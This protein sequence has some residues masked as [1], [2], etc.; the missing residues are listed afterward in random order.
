MLRQADPAFVLNAMTEAFLF[1]R[2]VCEV[3]ANSHMSRVVRAIDSGT[4][5]VPN[6]APGV[7]QYLIFE[8]ADGDVRKH[9]VTVNRFDTAW[10]LRALHHA[11]TGLTQLHGEGLAHQDLK[12]S[13]VLVFPEKTWKIGDLGRA[14]S[15]D[16]RSPHDGE[17]VAGDRAYAPPELL[18]H[19]PDPDWGK[20]RFG[21]DA[22]LLGSMVLFLFAQNGMTALMMDQLDTTQHWQ[23]WTGTFDEIL[24]YLRNAYGAALKSIEPALPEEHRPDLMNILRQLCDPD[25]KLRGHPE[26]RKRIGN[27]YSLERY[28]SWLNLLAERAEVQLRKGL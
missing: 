27:Q 25:P 12:P 14:A 22:Y 20:R 5:V 17:E 9:L 18:Y 16:F 1:E 8:L 4:V 19:Q 24:P 10:A 7:V 11:A 28:I 3:C 26:Q 6:H 2:K 15:R 21:C 23:N 13:N